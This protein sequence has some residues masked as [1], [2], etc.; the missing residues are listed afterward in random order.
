MKKE[1]ATEKLLLCMAYELA[2]CEHMGDVRRAV[3]A[4]FEFAGMEMPETDED[5]GGLDS[6]ALEER[7]GESFLRLGSQP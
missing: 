5:D 7:G 6:D 4:A 2:C 3:Y 1:I